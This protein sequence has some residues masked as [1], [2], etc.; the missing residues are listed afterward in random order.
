MCKHLVTDLD[1]DVCVGKRNHLLLVILL[2][3]ANV[4]AN[5]FLLYF[6]KKERKRYLI[7]VFTYTAF[8]LSTEL[9]VEN[10]VM[11]KQTLALCME[12]WQSDF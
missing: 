1:D 5:I 11:I 2:K 4:V 3:R 8:S 9:L 7:A 12:K 10:M 6:T